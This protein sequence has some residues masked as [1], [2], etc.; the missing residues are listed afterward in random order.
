MKPM[1]NRIIFNLHVKKRREMHTMC[2][3]AM[4]SDFFDMVLPKPVL[5]DD[6][7]VEVFTGF[8]DDSIT[9]EAFRD[10]R[11]VST[12]CPLECG[13][14]LP[15]GSET[16]P[17]ETIG[18]DCL[19]V[20]VSELPFTAMEAPGR[21]LPAERGRSGKV[22]LRFGGVSSGKSGRTIGCGE[23]LPRGPGEL[24]R[25]DGVEF[26]PFDIARTEEGDGP[27]TGDNVAAGVRRGGVAGRE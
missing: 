12:T 27:A 9:C 5:S 19:L 17:L 14:P 6:V 22:V 3:I 10:S 4:S 11:R 24:G 13:R 21:D 16:L 15:L 20:D 7:E 25:E 8:R 23:L 26:R 2:L 18:D 1:W